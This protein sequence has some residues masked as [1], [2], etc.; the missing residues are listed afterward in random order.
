MVDGVLLDWEGVLVDTGQ[1][2]REAM[3]RALADEGVQFD[4]PAYDERCLGRA[5]HGAAATAVGDISDP[6]LIELVSIRAEREFAAWL[7]QGFTLRP[8]VARMMELAQLRAPIAIVTAASRTETDVALRLA[9][10]HDSC[11]ALVTADDVSD[12]APS[13]SQY[14][15]A[16]ASLARRRRVRPGHVIALAVNRPSIRAA[17]DAGVRTIAIGTPAHISL[18]AD[19]TIASLEG[20]TVDELAIVAGL[21]AEERHA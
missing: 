20:I 9:D 13:R 18:E 21:S 15:K 3:L 16:L 2:R 8:G 12:V 17:R 14:V 11:A 10:L 7:A 1:S 6:T 19:G 4:S 5:V